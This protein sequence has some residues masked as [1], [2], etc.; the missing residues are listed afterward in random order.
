MDWNLSRREFLKG[1][2][3]TAL[4]IG[5]TAEITGL[6]NGCV[7]F[8]TERDWTKVPKEEFD[9]IGAE[10]YYRQNF[11]W[12]GISPHLVI[13]HRF[14]IEPTFKSSIFSRF[15]STPGMSYSVNRGENMVALAP[16][17]VLGVGKLNT[18][19]LG[20]LRVI[21]G[22]GTGKSMYQVSGTTSP[23]YAFETHYAHMDLDK[24]LVKGGQH[25]DRGQ[26]IGVV[27]EHLI[28]AKA[29]L[30]NRQD[31]NNYGLTAMYPDG[32]RHYLNYP[33]AVDMTTS[34]YSE[35]T[36]AE[37]ETK[38]QNSFNVVLELYKILGIEHMKQHLHNKYANEKRR[39]KWD[40]VE[41]FRFLKTLH[42]LNHNLFHGIG[43]QGFKQYED[44]FYE[45]W[46]PILLTLPLKKYKS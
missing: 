5:G 36:K 13:R 8:D 35:P 38:M 11:H 12:N 41:E 19:R 44:K 45:N 15:G 31:P 14:G 17:K 29:H 6:L 16:G 30:K 39:Y 7:T 32:K 18:G 22:H 4:A 34:V 26:P 40:T 25:V 23:Y 9:F 46:P 1:I 2:G 20:G 27:S 28:Q 3:K 24:R 37:I 33:D 21:I 43:K 42:S 10:N